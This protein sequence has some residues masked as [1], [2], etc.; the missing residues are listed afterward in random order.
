MQRLKRVLRWWP[1]LLIVIL[2]AAGVVFIPKWRSTSASETSDLTQVFTA[3]LGNLVSS[4]SP[5]GEVY[6]P[7]QVELSFDVYKVELIELNVTAGQKVEAGDVLARIDPTALERAVIQA[8]ADLTVAQDN[9]DK[10]Q[11]PYT[12]LDLTQAKVAMEQ[13][14]VALEEGKESLEEVQN[15]ATEL[16]LTQAKL[17]VAQAELDLAEAEENLE[18]AKNPNTELDL[19]QAKLSV[20]QA[21]IDLEDAKENLEE[22]Q[23]SK[24]DLDL[25][26]AKL[27]V[28]QAEIDLEGAKEDL[29]ALLDPDIE[30]A[31]ATV[32]DAE[33]ALAS[34]QSQLTVVEN[35]PDNAVRLRTLEA[36]A[37]WYRNNYWEAQQK[38]EEGKIGQQKLDWE[39]S[40]MLA[41][42]EK[43]TAAR[44][45]AESSLANA[46]NKVTQAEEALQ[47]A[48]ENL[49]T[50]LSG[51]DAT[52]LTRAETQVTQAEY[53]LAKAQENLADLEAGLDPSDLTRAETQVTQAEYNLA[54]AQ[55][56]LADLEAGSD[57]SEVARA[58]TQVAQAE[59]NLAKAKD[60]LADLE[61]GSDPSEVA[62]AEAQVTQ[63]EYNLAKAQDTLAEIE[64]GPDPNDIEVAQAKV[65]SA[66]ANLEEAQA[67]SEAATMVAP[68]GGTVI[69]VGAEVGD[70]VSS[71]NIV[72][73]L[74]DLTNLRV[75][76]IVD[77]TDISNVE[78]GQEVE[79]TFDAFPGH[80][81]W[82]Q[83]LEVPL[84]GTLSQNVLTYEVPISLEGAEDVAL[85][86]GM[87][88]NLEIVV[89]RRE[90]A[91]LVPALA[92]QQSEEGSV[93]MVQDTPEGPAAATPV[94]V[95][96][97][98]GTYVEIVSGLIEGDQV[99]VEYRASQDQIFGFGGGGN[100]I[101]GAGRMRP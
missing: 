81:F 89:G 78:I 84:Q 43:L 20:A 70:L 99:L 16:D 29:E 73:T 2:V 45:Q 66:Q 30:A 82:G 52:A 86:T 94:K 85:K 93:V 69:S 34:A 54:K 7:R 76:A 38:F 3:Q 46:Q 101:M 97:S 13:A 74:A 10:A 9:L 41:A 36:E 27:A 24:T 17:A 100:I 21:E 23:N 60:T 71:T 80:V 25:T 75:R 11:N 88:A 98:D 15:P 49:A 12:A 53:N 35:D 68:F 65:V 61:A 14:E 44:A 62:R 95:G 87:T 40:N 26:Q 39:Y 42:E 91:L 64:A 59:Y 92:V 19:T 57:P 32:R 58:E 48:Q 96:L 83:V 33:A 51:P 8:E 47:D 79:A 1:A 31:Q 5:T 6:A 22:V 18:K 77:E 90:D 37:D 67:A 4:I 72:V 28:A 50:L 63:A 56:N 55:E